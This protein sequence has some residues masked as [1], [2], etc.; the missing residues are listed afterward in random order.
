MLV[1]AHRAALR[2]R[3]LRQPQAVRALPDALLAGAGQEPDGEGGKRGWLAVA[4][5]ARG[6]DRPRCEEI[7][8]SGSEGTQVRK[9]G[10]GNFLTVLDVRSKVS[11]GPF[12]LWRQQRTPPC[13]FQLPVAPDVPWIVTAEF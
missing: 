1:L 5:P 10:N 2:L 8:E 3:F 4:W 11:A 13:L 7:G 12:S 9:G 6:A